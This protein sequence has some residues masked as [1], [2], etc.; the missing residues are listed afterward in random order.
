MKV[1]E[2]IIHCFASIRSCDRMMS[3]VSSSVSTFFSIFSA[4]SLPAEVI[5]ILSLMGVASCASALGPRGRMG[6]FQP[7]DGTSCSWCRVLLPQGHQARRKKKEIE[8][9]NCGGPH[10]HFSNVKCLRRGPSYKIFIGSIFFKVIFQLL[11]S[12]IQLS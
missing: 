8:V 1:E 3:R 11:L 10:D 12:A 6:T 5:V 9:N 2:E 4:T 7:T